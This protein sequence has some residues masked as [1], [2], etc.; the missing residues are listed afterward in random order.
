[1]LQDRKSRRGEKPE[2]CRETAPR[3]RRLVLATQRSHSSLLRL[4]TEMGVGDWG[5]IH[6]P[7]HVL[8]HE[9]GP[10]AGEASC[11]ARGTS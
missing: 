9:Q 7:V 8:T 4:P 1:M 11:A 5:L 2:H 6:Q 10:D 3:G